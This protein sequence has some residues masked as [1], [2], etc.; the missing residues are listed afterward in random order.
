MEEE[1]K[2]NKREIVALQRFKVMMNEMMGK[3]ETVRRASIAIRHKIPVS[4][5]SGDPAVMQEV[6]NRMTQKVIDM[7]KDLETIQDA[8]KL[9]TA[10]YKSEKQKCNIQTQQVIDARDGQQLAETRLLDLHQEFA[11]VVSSTRDII[12]DLKEKVSNLEGENE[13]LMEQAMNAAGEAAGDGGGGGIKKADA[14]KMTASVRGVRAEHN[15]IK[16]ETKLFLDE[17]GS[18]L[19][20]IQVKVGLMGDGSSAYDH[21]VMDQFASAILSAGTVSENSSIQK[22]QSLMKRRAKADIRKKVKRRRASMRAVM[23]ATVILED[24]THK[25]K[26]KEDVVVH[27][28]LDDEENTDDEDTIPMEE[29]EEFQLALTLKRRSMERDQ[30]HLEA[31]L[32]KLKS[33][34]AA[35]DRETQRKYF[36]AKRACIA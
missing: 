29:T 23:K 10:K 34:Q 36:K 24:K 33:K 3:V 31:K 6:V 2:T 15:G 9:I 5:L 25:E 27:N 30:R 21:H 19:N 7:E 18:M 26:I 11:D 22:R 16:E 32:R 17:Y 13:Y 8:K 12:D 14:L 4:K 1:L 20:D 35:V 28:A